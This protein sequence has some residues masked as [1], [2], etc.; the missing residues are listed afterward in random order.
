MTY[1]REVSR[2][3]SAVLH[4][5]FAVIAVLV[6]TLGAPAAGPRLAGWVCKHCGCNGT[7]CEGRELSFGSAWSLV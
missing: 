1:C 3:G 5:I 7:L 4:V 6:L 2:K